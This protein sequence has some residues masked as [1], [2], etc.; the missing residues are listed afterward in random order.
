M[1]V[2]SSAVLLYGFRIG[3][4]ETD[5]AD[6]L[7]T[8]ISRVLRGASLAQA[9]VGYARGGMWDHEELYLCTAYHSVE[10]NE[11]A[12]LALKDDAE[13][14][15]RWDGLLNAAARALGVTEHEPANWILMVH[16]S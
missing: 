12:S 5:E 8:H 1:S 4:P 14:C 15:A 16:E 13:T 2:D 9:G 6:S 11:P 10:L 7:D 3:E